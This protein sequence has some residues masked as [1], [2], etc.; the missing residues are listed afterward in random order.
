VNCS[1]INVAGVVPQQQRHNVVSCNT[2]AEQQHRSNSAIIEQ[3]CHSNN[4]IA[5]TTL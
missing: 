4:T 2:I 1:A 3:H 5:A